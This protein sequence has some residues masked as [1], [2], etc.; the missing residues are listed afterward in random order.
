MINKF[1]IIINA[2]ERLKLYPIT[3]INVKTN[4]MIFDVVNFK[5]VFKQLNLI[6]TI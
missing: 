5:L 2:F 4:R 6:K 1:K 3:L